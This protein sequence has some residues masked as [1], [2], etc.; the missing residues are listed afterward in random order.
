MKIYR[1]GEIAL[2]F[3]IYRYIIEIQIYNHNLF[4][5]DDYYLRIKINID[6]RWYRKH[7]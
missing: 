1:L 2:D 6:T 3:F 7:K 5:L 4:K